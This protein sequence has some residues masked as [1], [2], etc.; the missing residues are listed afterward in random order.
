[1]HL[2][3]TSK[4]SHVNN[5]AAQ[6]ISQPGLQIRVLIGKLFSLYLIQNICCG[7][8]SNPGVTHSVPTA[9]ITD[10]CS[11]YIMDHA[12]V[13]EDDVV[14]TQRRPLNETVLLSTQNTCLNQWVKK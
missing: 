3:L 9:F 1:M 6:L 13:T 8:L 4:C 12:L 14:G 7:I 10:E 2:T 5:D 11:W